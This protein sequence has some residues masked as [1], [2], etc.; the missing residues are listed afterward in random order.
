MWVQTTLSLL[1]LVEG[2]PLEVGSGSSLTAFTVVAGVELREEV[3]PQLELTLGVGI[4]IGGFGIRSTDEAM[5]WAIDLSAGARYHLDESLAV[6]LDFAPVIIVPT[7]DTQATG[8]HLAI[9]L[10]GEAHF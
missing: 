2:L 10:R 6:R 7:D 8:G 9:V 3:A 5:G 1:P 4:G